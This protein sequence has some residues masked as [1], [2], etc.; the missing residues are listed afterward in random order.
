M[1]TDQE[2]SQIQRDLTSALHAGVH[3]LR[4]WLS[5]HT[6]FIWGME[7]CHRESLTLG[8]SVFLMTQ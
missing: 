8:L 7:A 1:Q 6:N 5:Q 2:H 4:R 3:A